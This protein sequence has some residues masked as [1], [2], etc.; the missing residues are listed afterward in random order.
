MSSSKTKRGRV[1]PSVPAQPVA[2][3]AAHA[4]WCDLDE[5]DNKMCQAIAL[6]ATVRVALLNGNPAEQ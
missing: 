4:A 1:R 6:L 2:E 3:N 5:S